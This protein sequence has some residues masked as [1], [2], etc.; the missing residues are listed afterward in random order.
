MVIGVFNIFGID[1]NIL[2]STEIGVMN[3]YSGG[4]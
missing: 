1:L 4:E 2:C 3:T